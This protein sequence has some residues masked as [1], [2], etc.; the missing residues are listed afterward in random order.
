MTQKNKLAVATKEKR[1]HKGRNN[2]GVK[3]M[4]NVIII[5]SSEGAVR[6]TKEAAKP[7]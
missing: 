6:I 3:L 2:K 7:I 4:K 1:Q 5:R